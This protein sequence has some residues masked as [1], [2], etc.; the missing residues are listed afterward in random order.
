MNQAFHSGRKRN[1]LILAALFGT[2]TTVFTYTAYAGGNHIEL[3]PILT[4]ALDP[5]YLKNDFFTNATDGNISRLFYT[6][7]V[8]TAARTE[9][10]LLAISFIL[11]LLS[12]I[13]ISV[14]TFLFAQDLFLDSNM[15]GIY[16]AAL[17]MS[18]TSFAL[19]WRATI[20]FNSLI[21][22][23]LAIPLVLGA[24]W[25]T[26]RGRLLLAILICGITSLIH[27]LLGLEI[28]AILLLASAFFYLLEQRK[29]GR[30]LWQ[31]IIIPALVFTAFALISLVPQLQQPSIDAERFNYI[32]AA[33]RTPHHRLLSTFST[34]EYISAI[35]FLSATI[36]LYF[37]QRS[38]RNKNFNLFLAIT[39]IIVFLL[40][41]GGYLFVEV[42]PS[43]IWVTAQTYRLLYFI[44]WIGLIFVGGI[45]ANNKLERST[46]SMFMV[47]TLNSV[48]LGGVTWAYVIKEWLQ[49]RQY[50]LSILLHPYLILLIAVAILIYLSTSVLSLLLLG[51]YIFLIQFV[52]HFPQKNY[53]IPL[54]V[55]LATILIAAGLYRQLPDMGHS[56][57][58][59]SM[60]ELHD[61]KHSELGPQGDEVALLA[62]Q[63]T[64]EEAVFLTP[65]TFGHFR[66]L[67]RRAIV[68]DFKAF[69][70]SDVAMLDWYE[71]MTTIYGQPTDLGFDMIDELN[72]NYANINDRTI[73]ALQEKY[74]FSYAVLFSETPTDFQVLF[75][76]EKF[77]IINLED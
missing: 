76:N 26:A 28:G 18:V 65:P 34:Q 2:I 51:A 63:N 3:I 12:N 68:V 70:F 16:A 8:T 45:L 39:G 57:A 38:L 4:R 59:N 31:K 61:N 33:F 67:A 20:F 60:A 1:Y 73:L 41:L 69:P 10:N 71:R 29:I 32:L 30:E 49:K 72:G 7:L 54:L 52:N 46:R 37:G 17:A 5:T 66:I 56:T 50:R 22:A 11:T 25:A 40:T 36:I 6:K 42:L 27:P 48:T 14:V 74:P 13:A 43:R 21:P 64:P 35:A 15:A 47:G 77:K 23:T 62:R 58:V 55:L 19:G 44:R 75:Q 24:T 53:L 9:Q